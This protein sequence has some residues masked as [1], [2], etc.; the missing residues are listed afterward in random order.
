[1]DEGPPARPWIARSGSAAVPGRAERHGFEYFRQGTLSLYATFDTKTVR[2]SAKRLR[3][4]TSAEFVAF[5]P[6][7][8]PISLAAKK[9]V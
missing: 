4:R 5:L 1:V 8:E 6:R 9:S 2:R 7:L 3:G